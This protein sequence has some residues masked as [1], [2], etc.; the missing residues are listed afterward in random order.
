MVVVD[1]A[2]SNSQYKKRSKALPSKTVALVA[3]TTA[4]HSTKEKIRSTLQLLQL[5]KAVAETTS[6]KDNNKK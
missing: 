2:S 4:S 5:T 1:A 6:A 3:A